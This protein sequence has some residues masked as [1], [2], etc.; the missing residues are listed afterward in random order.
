MSVGEVLGPLLLR[1]DHV[2]LAVSDFDAAV[3]FYADTFGLP[4]VHEEI[5]EDQGVREGMLAVGDAH[6]QLL[7]PL[8]PDSTIAK[9]IARSGDGMQQIAFE[10]TDVVAAAALLAD[11]GV[12]LLYP[13]PRHGTAG[14]LVNFV[15]PKDCGGVL[16]E[17]VQLNK[18]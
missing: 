17:L 9:F 12:Q 5:N 16:V 11:R 3:A 2:G 4:L 14:S 18:H 8:S 10:V 13:E 15:H 7:A 6:L 1:I